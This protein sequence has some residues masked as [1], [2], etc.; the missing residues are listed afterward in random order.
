MRKIS[1]QK[2]SITGID[3]DVIVNAA[4]AGLDIVFAIL[5]DRII[6]LGRQAMQINGL[7]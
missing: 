7:S 1:I 4:N 3:T 2:I 5:S 6:E